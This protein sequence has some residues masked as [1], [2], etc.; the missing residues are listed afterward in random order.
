MKYQD[1]YVTESNR[2]SKGKE[3]ENDILRVQRSVKKCTTKIS[4]HAK[5]IYHRATVRG[6]AL[7]ATET[8]TLGRHA[9]AEQLVI[10]RGELS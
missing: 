2:S 10:K 5:I 3:V 1:E 8:V 6:A 4:T 7:Y 9:R